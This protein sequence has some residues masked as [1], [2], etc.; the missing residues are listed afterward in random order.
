MKAHLTILC[1][2]YRSSTL[3]F[4]WFCKFQARGF[5]DSFELPLD[6][7][8]K[9]TWTRRESKEDWFARYKRTYRRDDLEYRTADEADSD[10]GTVTPREENEARWAAEAA[11]SETLDKA[12]ARSYYKVCISSPWRCPPV[13]DF[14]VH[15]QSLKNSKA[16][17]K[18]KFAGAS[19]RDRSGAVDDSF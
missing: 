2:L 19:S 16:K 17:G 6:P 14:D 5:D 11:Q 12:E 7:T 8:W 15:L 13:P 4:I 10:R 18:T 1:S 9:P 3:N